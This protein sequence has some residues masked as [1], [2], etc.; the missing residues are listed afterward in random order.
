MNGKPAGSRQLTYYS[1][2]VDV[3]AG[4]SQIYLQQLVPLLDEVLLRAEPLCQVADVDKLLIKF[5]DDEDDSSTVQPIPLKAF[6]QLFGVYSQSA[7]GIG[8]HALSYSL[9]FSPFDVEFC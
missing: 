4:L 1:M 2:S 9:T 8:L 5:F 3:V 6:E 7:S